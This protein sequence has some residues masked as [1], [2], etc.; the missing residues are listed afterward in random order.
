M[1]KRPRAVFSALVWKKKTKKDAQMLEYS[2]YN[3]GADMRV[4]GVK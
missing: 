4:E 2:S 1:I 3:E